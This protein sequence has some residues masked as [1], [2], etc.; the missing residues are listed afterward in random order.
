V[1]PAGQVDILFEGFWPGV[2]GRL[3]IG[4]AACW[5][6]NPALVYGR[7]TGWGQD[8]PLAQTAGHDIVYIAP[9]GALNTIGEAGATPQIPV[10]YVGDF[11][12]GS[13]YLAVG[14]LAALHEARAS[15]R[16]ANLIAGGE[17]FNGVYKAIRVTG[18]G[19]VSRTV[20]A[21][22]QPDSEVAG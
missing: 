8:G 11:G 22:H 15:G 7:L 12:G 13:L 5:E 3:G 14:M 6:R 19:F 10:N 2:A 21:K 9:T 1:A 4:P 17:P 20:S 16:G 18:R